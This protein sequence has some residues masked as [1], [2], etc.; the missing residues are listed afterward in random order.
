V[1]GRLSHYLIS[2]DLGP[3]QLQLTFPQLYEQIEQRPQ[4]LWKMT[5]WG[6][7]DFCL[8]HCHFLIWDWQRDL[9]TTTGGSVPNISMSVSQLQR[10]HQY[11]RQ[12]SWSLITLPAV[13][14][15]LQRIIT[16]CH[17]SLAMWQTPGNNFEFIY[18]FEHVTLHTSFASNKHLLQVANPLI[19]QF[20]YWLD[21]AKATS[22]EQF[23]KV[24]FSH[25]SELYKSPLDYKGL[26]RRPALRHC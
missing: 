12:W 19:N 18:Q 9:S 25:Y 16:K 20:L 8:L 13:F 14:K 24:P 22:E 1:Y 2:P 6:N 4:P 10:S 26:Q 23:K 5:L 17:M 15:S 3:A 11:T 21:Y 7:F